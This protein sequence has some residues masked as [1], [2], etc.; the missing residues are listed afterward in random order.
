MAGLFSLILV[1]AVIAAVVFLIMLVVAAIIKK[2]KKVSGIGTTVSCCLAFVAMIGIIFTYHPAE[3]TLANGATEHPTAT[4]ASTPTLEPTLEPTEM[5]TPTLTPTV[6]PT[7]TPEP[8]IQEYSRKVITSGDMVGTCIIAITNTTDEDAM[9]DFTRYVDFD[10]NGFKYVHFYNS[11]DK[12]PDI[13]NLD[14]SGEDVFFLDDYSDGR[15]FVYMIQPYGGK[16][17]VF[18]GNF[19]ADSQRI[20]N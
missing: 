6:T 14:L 5:P 16:E 18:D 7:T 2:P 10:Y 13:A 19:D 9:I 12:A 20:L 15:I 4:L 8:D 1:V 17:A 3:S 11:K